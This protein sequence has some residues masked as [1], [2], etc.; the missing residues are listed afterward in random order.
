M[1]A[2]IP[3]RTRDTQA[4]AEYFDRQL[5]F[6]I[7]PSDLATIVNEAV[8]KVHKKKGKQTPET[9]SGPKARSELLILDIRDPAAYRKGHIP[10]AVNLP[11]EAWDQIEDNV[12]EISRGKVALSDT[13]D[14]IICGYGKNCP[15]ARQAAMLFAIMGYP[16]RVLDGGFKHWDTEKYMTEFPDPKGSF[17]SQLAVNA[18]I[19]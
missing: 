4:A 2:D 3:E 6:Y 10:N 18:D 14:N 16:V 5:T 13:N 19:Y 7:C 11:F 8:H 1:T 9:E 17:Y 12:E 15:L